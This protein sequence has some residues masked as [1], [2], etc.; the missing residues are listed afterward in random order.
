MFMNPNTFFYTI[1]VPSK[2]YYKRVPMSSLGKLFINNKKFEI[3]EEFFLSL[4]LKRSFEIFSV[5]PL[6][7][8]K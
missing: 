3:I 4:E 5:N 7:K 8:M 1:A 2:N 6:K